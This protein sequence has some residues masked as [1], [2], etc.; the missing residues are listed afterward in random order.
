R[1]ARLPAE[2]YRTQLHVRGRGFVRRSRRV[3]VSRRVRQS[4]SVQGRLDSQQLQPV[5]G[6]A[7][8]H[9]AELAL[10]SAQGGKVRGQF[11]RPLRVLAQSGAFLG[12]EIRLSR[13]GVRRRRPQ[14]HGFALRRAGQPVLAGSA[15]ALC[16]QR[17]PSCCGARRPVHFPRFR[18]LGAEHLDERAHDIQVGNRRSRLLRQ[19]RARL[20]DLGE[21]RS[22][23]AKADRS[24]GD[25]HG[26]LLRRDR[27]R[28][29]SG[30]GRARLSLGSRSY[31][32]SS[33]D[34][35]N[36]PTYVGGGAPSP[37]FAFTPGDRQCKPANIWGGRGAISQEAIDFFTYDRIV[38]ESI[39][40]SVVTG[41]I[42]GDS[43]RLFSL[44]GGPV[45]FVLGAEWRE[46]KSRQ[47]FDEYD[48]GIIQVAGV[49]PD[50]TPYSPGDFVGD[51]SNAAALGADPSTT[52]ANTD[53][54]YDV[55]D[56]FAELS[57]PLLASKPFADEL[58]ID[59]AVRRADYS[60]FGNNTTYRYGLVWAPVSDVRFRANYSRAIRVPNLFELYSPEQGQRFRPVDPCDAGQISQAPDPALRQENVV[61]HHA[62]SYVDRKSVW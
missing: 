21:L 1:H 58:T 13:G 49:T 17:R 20:R 33:D 14:F 30:D 36:I 50:G 24:R 40:Q 19:A 55:W 53:A 5:R 26:P 28:H 52:L 38:E 60:T 10:R 22:V 57:L 51:V 45:G 32:V 3:L 56:V 42:S 34:P 16:R 35:F 37:F 41:F 39:E 61:A 46:E 25:D 4:R 62:T 31:R 47:T 6:I 7:E 12:I 2:L 59:A 29:A 8:L 48:R 15:E 43:S 11:Q 9:R 23:R 18:R 54:S 44:P 27:R